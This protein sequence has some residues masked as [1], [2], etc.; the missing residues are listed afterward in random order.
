MSL[1]SFSL[2]PFVTMNLLLTVDSSTLWVDS[3]KSHQVMNVEKL[4]LLMRHHCIHCPLNNIEPLYLT[5]SYNMEA[6][7]IV[8]SIF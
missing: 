7:H 8:L 5:R 6:T 3:K 4:P 2:R 1:S